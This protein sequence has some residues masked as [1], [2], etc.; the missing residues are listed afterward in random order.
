MERNE[1]LFGYIKSEKD[2]NRKIFDKVYGTIF[3]HNV[4]R[5]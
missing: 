2:N 3:F 5:C 1:D 4:W